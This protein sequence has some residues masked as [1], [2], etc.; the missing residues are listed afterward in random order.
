ML[1]LNGYVLLSTVDLLSIPDPAPV[2]LIPNPIK[3]FL[4][5]SVHII[6]ISKHFH[7]IISYN[8]I[9]KFNLQVNGG[10]LMSSML[11]IKHFLVEL[12]LII[13]MHTPSMENLEIFIHAL[14]IVS[15]LFNFLIIRDV[16]NII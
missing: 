7:F 8:L 9:F 11:K 6:S 1:T 2:I 12:D 15:Y 5:Y 10:T 13:P 16:K 3:K 14:K 4:L